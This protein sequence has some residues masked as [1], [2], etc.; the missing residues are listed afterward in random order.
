[1]RHPVDRVWSYFQMELRWDPLYPYA[2]SAR[3]GL[4]P[5]L[6]R[7]WEVRNMATRYLSGSILDEA[8]PFCFFDSLQEYRLFLRTSRFSKA[9]RKFV[10]DVRIVGH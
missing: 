9:C 10:L 7:C 4:L 8:N 3:N 1:M 5:F 6:E 2:I